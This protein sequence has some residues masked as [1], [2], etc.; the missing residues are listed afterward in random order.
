[1]LSIQSSKAIREV[2]PLNLL[3][4]RF[5]ISSVGA[6]MYFSWSYSQIWSQVSLTIFP[7]VLMPNLKL[8]AMVVKESPVLRYLKPYKMCINKQTNEFNTNDLM[9]KQC[10]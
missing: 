4:V 10:V 7:T 9:S 2:P 6:G 3:A 5:Q 8:L 1:M